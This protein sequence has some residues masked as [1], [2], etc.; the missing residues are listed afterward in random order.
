MRLASIT[1][2][3]TLSRR[4]L[5]AEEIGPKRSKRPPEKRWWGV[6]RPGLGWRRQ[7]S[8]P[9]AG[10][11]PPPSSGWPP[12]PPSPPASGFSFDQSS[13]FSECLIPPPAQ[14]H[15]PPPP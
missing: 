11:T 5:P 9:A 1:L 10:S 4:L 8:E 3:P 14:S 13:D 7:G 12:P 15:V 2:R 6:P